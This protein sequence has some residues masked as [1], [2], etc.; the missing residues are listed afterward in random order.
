MPTPFYHLSL[1]EDLSGH[2]ALSGSARKFLRSH[3]YAFLLGSTAPDVQ[4]LTGQDRVS[5]HF[6]ELPISPATRPAWERILEEYPVL[7]APAVLPADQ[8][9]FIAGYLCHLQA[10]W[11]WVLEI[12]AP[13]FGP[14]QDWL[15]FRQRLYL[16]NVLRSF[17]DYKLMPRLPEDLGAAIRRAEPSGWLPFVSDEVLCRWRDLLAVQLEP[18]API[19]T[20]EIF[21]ARQGIPAEE[22][23]RMI[24]SEDQLNRMIFSRLP[25]EALHSFRQ[26]LILEHLRLVETYL[27]H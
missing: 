16:H 20:V 12:F 6:F 9:A 14:Y 15:T 23:Y 24:S 13:V 4:N 17:L 26:R 25:R 3:R 5:T 19:Q 7:A 22:Y 2:P 1:A 10:D 21:A 18:G 27:P 8:A 11:L